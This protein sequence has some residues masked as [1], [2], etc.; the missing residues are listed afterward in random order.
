MK[1]ALA[2]AW[3]DFRIWLII[4][5]TVAIGFCRDFAAEIRAARHRRGTRPGG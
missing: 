5:R 1:N 4:I 3:N 2:A